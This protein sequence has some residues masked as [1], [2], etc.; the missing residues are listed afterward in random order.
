MSAAAIYI[1][2]HEVDRRRTNDLQGSNSLVKLVPEAGT[3]LP[4][5]LA[6]AS[7]IVVDDD[8]Q[9]LS[10]IGR[11]LVRAGFSDV[12]V[13]SNPF[14]ALD[15]I[16]EKLPDLV[17]LDIHMPEMDGFRLLAHLRERAGCDA[18]VPALAMTGSHSPETTRKALHLGAKD[19]VRKPLDPAELV[20]RVRNLL[21]MRFLYLALE[22]D[23][24]S[25]EDRLMEQTG[26]L[27]RVNIDTLQRLAHAATYR[28]NATGCHTRRVGDLSARIAEALDLDAL[29]VERIRIAASVHD[30]GKIGIADDILLKPGP[31]TP[32]EFETMKEHTLIGARL[33]A[34]GTSEVMRL[35]A[36]IART[37][38]E[39]FDGTGYPTGLAGHDIPLAGRIVAVADVFDALNSERP[40]RAAWPR[41]RV[42]AK[43]R[44]GSGTHFDREVVEAFCSCMDFEGCNVKVD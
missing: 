2:N 24:R 30:V 16:S 4:V 21:E 25:L 39:R 37:H 5:R 34:D 13:T 17:L 8:E 23:K 19:L 29:T 31:L 40:Y 9:V 20:L 44:E 43:I 38:H 6:T 1:S 36:V 32:A 28:D 22:G 11:L 18:F 15:W 12:R 35:A 10:V 33:C 27:R 26:E 42:L 3:P 7:I 41:E 14:R